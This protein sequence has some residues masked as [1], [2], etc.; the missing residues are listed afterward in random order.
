MI[1]APFPARAACIAAAAA[2]ALLLSACGGGSNNRDN[3][4]EETRLQD[5]RNAFAV[6]PQALAFAALD[7]TATQ[8]DRWSGTL[9]VAGYRIEVP[10]NWNGTL[11]MYTHGYAGE[12]NVLSVS[13]P[14]IRRYLIDNGYAW[15]ASS[16]SKNFYDVRA[17]VEDTNALANA[18]VQI[19]A[20]NGRMLN[21]PGRTYITGVSMGGHVAAAAIEDETLATARNTRRYDGA[22][23]M[24]GVLG[25][26]ALYDY[27]GAYQLAAQKLAGLPAAQFPTTDWATVGP[28]VRT[29]LF[30]SQTS[31][32]NPTAQGQKLKDVVMNLTGGRRPIFDQG[33]ANN[34][35]QNTVWGTFGRDGTINGIL[36]R[37][38]VDTTRIVYNYAADA[39]ELTQFNAT[40]ARSVP[41]ADANR[42]RRDGLRWFPK[43]NGE[44][45]IPVVTIHTLGDMYVPFK[46][47]QVYRERADAAGNGAWLVQRAIRA[48]SH[49]D[50]TVAEQVETFKAMADWVEKGVK[51]AGDNVATPAVLADANYGCAYTRD[52]GGVDDSATTLA[53]RQAMPRCAAR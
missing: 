11:V 41:V 30:N 50:F 19:A 33:F 38:A 31:F 44:F 22:A 13:N 27:F 24:C 37:N 43:V 45:R 21:A 42:L 8:T 12:G 49:C 5:S 52:T 14:A 7:G 39:A 29:A 26:L 4:P 25:D 32:A 36:N 34:S 23:P 28:Q 48:P 17:G 1:V 53:T 9:G 2:S 51:P 16:Y 46:M 6:N 18:F 15:A 20:S 47:E 40:I 3:T 10:R 35:L